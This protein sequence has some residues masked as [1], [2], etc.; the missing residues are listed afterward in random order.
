[1]TTEELLDHIFETVQTASLC[2]HTIGE[3]GGDVVPLET[4]LLALHD[5][6]LDAFFKEDGKTLRALHRTLG[7]LVRDLLEAAYGRKTV[8]VIF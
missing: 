6:A 3:R 4:S 8:A 7:E 1:M 2:L 5:E